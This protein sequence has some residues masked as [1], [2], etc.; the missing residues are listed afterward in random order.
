MRGGVAGLAA[1][2]A[3]LIA[4][5]CGYAPPPEPGGPVAGT[6]VAP[7]AASSGSPGAVDSFTD[8]AGLKV[9]TLPDGLKY[10]DL[11]IGD[12]PVA[13][14]DHEV[15]VQYT[16]WTADGKKFDSSRDRGQ[17]FVVSPIGQGKVIPGWDEG[18]PG[19]K[20]G[21]KRKLIIPPALAYGSQGSP[22]TIPANAT[23]TF[24]IELLSVGAVITPTPTPP[25]T[26]APSP[27]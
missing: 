12:G 11:K 5:G 23:L 16:G 1:A 15:T 18:V 21:G 17:P 6:S 10:I 20:V 24:D 3:L 19:M 27:K 25:P 2:A 22:P 26:A 13:Q 7:S 14:R 9:V 4:A 8:G